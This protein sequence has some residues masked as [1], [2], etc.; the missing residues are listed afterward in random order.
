MIQLNLLFK[1]ALRAK[2]LYFTVLLWIVI[3]LA[4]IKN[5]FMRSTCKLLRYSSSYR[6]GRFI[7]TIFLNFPSV[8]NV[9]QRSFKLWQSG[10][11]R[12]NEK[13]RS[14]RKELDFHGYKTTNDKHIKCQDAQLIDI[15]WNT[16]RIQNI[17][18]ITWPRRDSE[19][20][21]LV[22]VE[23]CHTRE[24]TRSFTH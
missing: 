23:K 7:T 22:Y 8:W 20:S 3:R 11:E 15:R 10:W 17:E 4:S 18:Y 9:N 16:L 2:L 5:Q 21:L 1:L 19:I 24:R 13:E 14:I 12:K 6:V